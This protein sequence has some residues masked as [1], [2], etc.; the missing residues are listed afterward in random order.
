MTLSDV[1]L[2]ALENK[3]SAGSRND[4]ITYNRKRT[5]TNI[6]LR[7]EQGNILSDFPAYLM[8]DKQVEI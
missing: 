2:L 7:I 3:H 1:V 4:V 6:F 5:A 8:H